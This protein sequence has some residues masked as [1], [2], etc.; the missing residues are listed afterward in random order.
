MFMY[1]QV[2]QVHV[3]REFRL[4]QSWA[5]HITGVVTQH[6]PAFL[7]LISTG[8]LSAAVVFYFLWS[9]IN[10]VTQEVVS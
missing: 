4:T 7:A 2:P 10:T 3:F 1:D 6:S 9:H 8:L 5:H